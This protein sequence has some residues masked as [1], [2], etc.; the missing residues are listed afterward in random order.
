MEY[1]PKL[2]PWQIN[3]QD[4]PRKGNSSEKL[5]FLL[6]YAILAPSSFNTQPWKFRVDGDEIRIFADKTWWLKVSDPDMRELYISIGCALENLLVAAEHFGYGHR[7]SYFPVP[8]KEGLAVA[9]RFIP[10]DQPSP[11]RN[12][13]LFG[14]IPERRTSH[15]L[16]ENRSIP[17]A[18][19][20]RLHDC[21]VEE[22]ISLYM[23][24]DSEFKRKV[25]GLITRADIIQYSDPAY[26]RELGY[27]IGQGV[28]GTSWLVS[29]LGQLAFT[30]INR[31]K[32]QAR[33]DSEMLMSA[34]VLACIG[35]KV[36]DR[37]S[38][39]KTGQVFERVCLTASVL[40]IRI[41]PMSQI[42]EIPE[43]KAG[44]A[45]LIPA[46][47]LFPQHIFR[48]GY[49]KQEAEHTPRRRLEEVLV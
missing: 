40:G 17:E 32:R 16:Y 19:L 1:N 35:S 28:F 33:E 26:R 10:S 31:G 27:W 9:V 11:S 4:F 24:G 37:T 22:G 34:P 2:T 47:D 18:D 5:K 30:Y 48:I 15:N 39:V 20:Q 42:L 38:H 21:C 43:L 14:A 36:N 7:V 6:R 12:H 49:A 41:Q 25:E 45:K 3:E 44:L 13:A 8:E 46:M 23:T 29:R